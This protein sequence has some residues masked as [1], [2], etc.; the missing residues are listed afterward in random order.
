MAKKI[1]VNLTFTADTNQAKQQIQ[2]LNDELTAISNKNI[3]G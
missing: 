3:F 2:K 1:N